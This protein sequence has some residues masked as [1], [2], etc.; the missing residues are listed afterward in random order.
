MP[1]IVGLGHAEKFLFSR[2][3]G[4]GGTKSACVDGHVWT[5]MFLLQSLKWGGGVADD[6]IPA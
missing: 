1:R 4:R 6:A 2:S 3:K 5:H